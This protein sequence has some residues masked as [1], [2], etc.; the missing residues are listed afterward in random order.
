MPVRVRPST[1]RM[2]TRSG[3]KLVERALIEHTARKTE[4]MIDRAAFD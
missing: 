3:G 4:E 1:V 2:R